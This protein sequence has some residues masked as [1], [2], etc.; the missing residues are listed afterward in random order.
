MQTDEEI[1]EWVR[2]DRETA[3]LPLMHSQ[4]GADEMSVVDPDTF[5][6]HGTESLQVVDASVMPYIT[7]Q[8]LHPGDDD[9]RTR[10]RRHPWR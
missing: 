6:V 9:C 2:N 8:H 1:L 3:L 5:R 7:M 4:M 10:R